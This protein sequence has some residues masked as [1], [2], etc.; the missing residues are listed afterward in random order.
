MTAQNDP[1]AQ[2]ASGDLVVT[3][4]FDAPRE[5][6]WQ[7]WTDPTHLMRWWGPE[8]FSAPTSNI[9]LRVGG[10]DRHVGHGDG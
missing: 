4:I 2:S 1:P 8:G 9:D 7:A 10:N 6:V 3:R 5:L